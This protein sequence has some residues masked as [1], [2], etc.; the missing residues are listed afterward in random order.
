MIYSA[1][2]HAREWIASEVDRRLMYWYV[3]RWRQN[4]KDVKR[5][6]KNT[7]LWFVPVMNPDGYEYT[8]TTSGC[9]ARTC[10]TT[11]ATA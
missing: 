1:T 4:D 5:L 8:F 11:T 6:L 2:Q 10:S 9:G 3:D 7:E